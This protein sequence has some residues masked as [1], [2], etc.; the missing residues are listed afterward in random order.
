MFLV[1]PI[2]VPVCYTPD[3]ELGIVNALDILAGDWTG[4][5]VVRRGLRVIVFD[6]VPAVDLDGDLDAGDLV[7]YRHREP[8]SIKSGTDIYLDAA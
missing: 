8:K 4:R 7:Q 2:V 1:S 3:R 5:M 6:G